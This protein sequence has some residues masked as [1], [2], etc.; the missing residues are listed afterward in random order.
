VLESRREFL[1]KEVARVHCLF[2]AIV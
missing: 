1:A 2:V